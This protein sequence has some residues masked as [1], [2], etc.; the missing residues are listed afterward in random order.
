METTAVYGTTTLV[1]GGVLLFWFRHL[2]Y[3]V[4]DLGEKVVETTTIVAD[5]SLSTYA[6]TVKI[7]NAK[8]RSDQVADI[9]DIDQVVSN[10]DIDAML[11][12]LYKDKA[13]ATES[14]TEQ[15]A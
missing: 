1:L 13:P 14:E 9:M 12:G 8:T 7:L 3:K 15:A 4:V 6:N 5:D 10:D 11:A 2:V